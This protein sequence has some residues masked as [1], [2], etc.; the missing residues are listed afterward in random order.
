[1]DTTLKRLATSFF[2]FFFSYSVLSRKSGFAPRA[3]AFHWR[4]RESPLLLIRGGKKR[5]TDRNNDKSDFG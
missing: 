3:F 1:M 2:L 4:A 5:F